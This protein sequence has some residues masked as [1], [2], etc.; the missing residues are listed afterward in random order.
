MMYPFMEMSDGTV[1]EH[2]QVMEEKGRK[3]VYVYFERNTKD[4]YA[5]AKCQLPDYFWMYIDGFTNEEVDKFERLLENSA[6][7]LPL[8]RRKKEA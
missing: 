7:L 3:R 6:N 4:G 2:S 1:V 8:A 5:S